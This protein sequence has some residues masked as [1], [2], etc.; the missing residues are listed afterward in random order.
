MTSLRVA[1]VGA[2]PAGAYTAEALLK[3]GLEH[4][5]A[6]DLIDRLPTPWGLVRSGVAPDHPQIKSV[7]RVFERIAD[8]P[9]VRF[10]GGVEV[11]VTVTHADLLAAYDAVVYA[12]GA[13]APRMLGIPGETLEGVV[14]AL[15]LVRWYNGHPDA[16]DAAPLPPGRTRAVV[17]GNGNVA[18]DCARMLIQDVDRLRRTDAADRAV[19]AL[20][21]SRIDEVVLLG[22]RGPAEASFSL[23]ELRELGEL[24]DV[25]IVADPGD[26]VG[27]EPGVELLREY[28]ARPAEGRR[29]RL[30]FRFRAVPVSVVGDDRVTGLEIA[31]HH[32]RDGTW[33]RGEDRQVLDCALVVPGVGFAVRGPDGLPVD[34]RGVVSHEDG[35]VEDRVYVA[36]WAK[37]GPSGVIGTNRKDAIETV[38]T[39]LGDLAAGRLVPGSAAGEIDDLLAERDVSVVT[40]AGWR[41]I[42][43]AEVAAAEDTDRPR[44]KLTR[45][46]ELRAVAAGN[47]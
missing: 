11:G 42:D 47:A 29:K 37:R 36:G 13:E 30:V 31:S 16:E 45:L 26:L 35:R 21:A 17:V 7:T 14:P 32:Q 46:P 10:L 4:P 3:A 15:D 22:R 43:A 28:V 1:I 24:D 12:L 25:R 18:L 5:V 2:G 23:V 8:R 9:G 40:L 6:V 19:D 20:A 39:L 38:E 33:V 27:D 34:G 44:V 41:A